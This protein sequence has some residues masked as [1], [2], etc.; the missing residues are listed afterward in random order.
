MTNESIDTALGTR[1]DHPAARTDR[2]HVNRRQALGLLAGLAG[3]TALSWPHGLH[4]KTKGGAALK[5]PPAGTLLT[6]KSDLAKEYLKALKRVPGFGGASLP[7]RLFALASTTRRDADLYGIALTAPAYLDPASG[8]TAPPVVGPTLEFVRGDVNGVYLTNDITICGTDHN[9]VMTSPQSG[10]RPHGY[11]TTNLHTH[12]LHV[13]PQAPSDDVLLS[14]RSGADTDPMMIAQPKLYPYRYQMPGDHPVGT[15]WYHPHKHGA[16][17]SQVGPGMSGA[18]IVRSQ[19]GKP[20]FD[21][22]IA[23]APYNITRSD[24][25]ILVLQT[26]P[27]YF[28]NAEETEGVFY[29]AGYYVKGAPDPSTCYG[30][31]LTEGDATTE[32]PTTVNGQRIPTLSLAKGQIRRLRFVNATNGQTYVPKLRATD[33]ST[34]LPGLY[35]VAVDGITLLPMPGAPADQPYFKVDQGLREGDDPSLYWTTAE[36]IT[37]APG[38]RLD[39]LIQADAPGQFELYGATAGESPMVTEVDDP[40]TDTLIRI[41]VGDTAHDTPQSLPPMS[42]F[43]APEIQRPVPPEVDLT[44]ANLPPATRSLEFKTVD[45]AFN[46]SGVPTYPAFLI[47]DQYFDGNL[48]DPAQIQLYKGDTDVWNLFSTNDAH[49]FHIHINSFQALA[50]VP[51][52]KVNRVYAAPIPYRFPI[53]RDTIYFDGGPIKDSEETTFLPGTMV[54]MAS[55][56]VDFTGEFVLHCHNLF[57]E[58]NGMMVTV[59]ILDPATGALDPT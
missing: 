46:A 40:N 26:I 13:T 21:D 8:D 49:I 42:L 2:W 5:S 28:S 29:P 31:T 56:Q 27:Y 25:E 33:G 18:L 4:A 24:E 17:A 30:L 15:F 39:L 48:D 34:P 11:T 3:S 16:V 23:A 45:A 14:I 9:I 12:G 43:A 54:V 47:N 58:D 38:Q 53:W 37:L 52:D 51:Y 41:D 32:P 19:D 1:S 55:K 35:A 57:H 59:S 22:L 10:W 50:R 36:I 44:G 6:A 7:D 20:D